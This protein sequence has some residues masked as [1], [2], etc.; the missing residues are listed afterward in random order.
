MFADIT[1]YN[2]MVQQSE[3]VALANV[4]IHRK[5]LQ[6]YTEAYNGQVITFYG[7]GSLS[8]YPSAIDAIKC[9]LKMQEAYREHDIPVRIGLHLG[10]IVYRGDSVYGDGVNVAS[11]V[12]TQG[13]AG[14]I[15]I[16]GKLQQE[17]G[18]HPEI[19]TKAL[20]SYKL[21]NVKYPTELYALTNSGLVVPAGHKRASTI[22]KIL[23]RSG[24]AVVLALLIGYFLYDN[25]SVPQAKTS[26]ELRERQVAVRFQ[27]FAQI[28]DRLEIPAMAS[29]WISNRLR[30]LPGAHV[31]NFEDALAEP[32]VAIASAGLEKR[33]EFAKRTDAVTVLEGT[34]YPQGDRLLFEA[35]IYDLESGES[36]K[37][38]DVVECDVKDPMQGI[39]KLGNTILG[40]WAT[41]DD[42]VY[43]VP[44]Y[45]AY[46]L[47]LEARDVWIEDVN[48]A[49]VKLKESISADTTFIDP[50]FLIT[51]LYSNNKDFVQRDSLLVLIKSRFNDLTPSQRSL[52]DVYEAEAGGDL[53]QTYQSYQAELLSDPLDV[54]VNTAGMVQAVQHVNRPRE[55]VNLFNMI[56][57]ESI[58]MDACAYCQTRLR[59]VTVAY[60]QLGQ[61]DSAIYISNILPSVSVN[62]MRYKL[63]PFATLN[64]TVKI[65]RLIAEFNPNPKAE[66][67]LDLYL[68]MAWRFKLQG[69][70]D[71]VKHYAELALR[72]VPNANQTSAITVECNYLLGN[73]VKVTELIEKSWPLSR[74]P[75]DEYVLMWTSRAYARTGT[76]TDRDRVAK[77]IDDLNASDSHDYGRSSYM[78]AVMSL[79][80]GDKPKAI[81]LLDQAYKSGYQFSEFRYQNDIDLMPLFGD[82]A[83][84]QI[85]NPLDE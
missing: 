41:K 51:E 16:S 70:D 34:I 78:L 79:I 3:A 43:S 29:H 25:L 2:A 28:K 24:L 63:K 58:D 5:A 77:L 52:M 8:T 31:V 42:I 61:V 17:I 72:N 33:R 53:I 84:K 50:Y 1:G 73:Y 7:N 57:V 15:L 44:N 12:Q 26:L 19:Q 74:F 20:G 64:D 68:E 60:L 4:D 69:R 66:S 40:W 48:L 36:L 37:A 45:E 39:S 13:V 10:D 54:F 71:L 11:R 27:D 55:A 56:P 81:S 80:E 76:D 49:E 6:K 9:A 47:F 32:E 14:S 22:K 67:T 23:L 83:F 46:Q 75:D 59:L 18:N 35:H 65:N 85:I 62:N 38:F 21:K 82:L 30:A